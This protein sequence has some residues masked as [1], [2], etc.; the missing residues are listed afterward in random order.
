MTGKAKI[1]ALTSSWYGYAVFSAAFS[2]LENGL[3]VGSILKT[4]TGLVF[5]WVVMF[6]LG[7]ALLRKSGVVRS[8]LLVF[9]ALL[10]VGGALATG[11]T[12]WAFVHTWQLGLLVTVVYSAASTWMNAK[13]FR[14]LTDPSVK[15]YFS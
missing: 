2:L 5:T 6:F 12:A 1:E 8:L 11:R 10:T 3:G 13:S 4:G 15:A 7:R 14:T 9:S